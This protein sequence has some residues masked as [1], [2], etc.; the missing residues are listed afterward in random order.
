MDWSPPGSSVHRDSPGKTTGVGCHALL[1]GIFP[2]QGWNPGLLHCRRILY[3]LSHQES[4]W[5]LEWVAYL[6]SRGSSRPRNWNWV[7]CIAEFF[8]SWVTKKAPIPKSKNAQVPYMK[9]L[10]AVGSRASVVGWIR[11]LGTLRE[12]CLKTLHWCVRGVGARCVGGATK[13]LVNVSLLH[14]FWPNFI[15]HLMESWQ[16]GGIKTQGDHRGCY[17]YCAEQ[18]VIIH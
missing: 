2:T 5:T 11:G 13:W 9:S 3:H 4:P 16:R 8:T 15:T 17:V 14:L 10:Y 7:S 6:F 1:Q 12:L 18:T